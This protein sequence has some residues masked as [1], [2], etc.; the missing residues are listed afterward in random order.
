MAGGP[1]GKY[2]ILF[3]F[4]TNGR[5]YLRQIQTK[6]GIWFL[7]ARLPTNHA[8]ALEGWYT[9]TGLTALLGQDIPACRGP[10]P[11]P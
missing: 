7:D 11:A 1:W 9:S 2:R 6:S 5:P 10:P 8:R 4:A 3:L